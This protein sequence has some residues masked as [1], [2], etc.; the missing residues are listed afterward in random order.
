[1]VTTNINWK[2]RRDIERSVKEN[3][4]TFVCVYVWRDQCK[5]QQTSFIRLLWRHKSQKVHRGVELTQN[6]FIKISGYRAHSLSATHNPHMLT[7]YQR[8]ERKKTNT[9]TRTTIIE[10]W[11]QHLMN[12]KCRSRFECFLFCV[13]L[14]FLLHS[15]VIFLLH[16][17]CLPDMQWRCSAIR[18]R[19]IYAKQQLTEIMLVLCGTITYIKQ[20]LVATQIGYS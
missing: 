11:H 16:L 1:M 10:K 19:G 2:E 8:I 14:L 6:I 13:I 20:V 15:C 12:E 4:I 3:E 5:I 7:Q 18:Q 9:N 17:F